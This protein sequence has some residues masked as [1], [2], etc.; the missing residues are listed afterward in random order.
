M[1]EQVIQENAS[2]I[3]LGKPIQVRLVSDLQ[4]SLSYYR[5]CLGC[6]VDSWGHAERGDLCFILQQAA[7][8]QDV[9]PNAVS[10]KRPDYP[11]EWEGP[12]YGWDTFVHI[13][14]EELDQLVEEVRAKGGL[15]G[16]EP[17]AGAHGG[18]EFKNAHII[19]PDG[20]NIVLGAMRKKE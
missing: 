2:Y 4:K 11:T 5:D 7:S 8:S 17:F 3:K 1:K 16:I 13:G 15:I 20:Y 14:W 18:W 6:K 19:D 10:A 12:E 9:K